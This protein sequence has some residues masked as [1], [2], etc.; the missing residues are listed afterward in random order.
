M[1][2]K[3]AITNVQVKKCSSHDPNI[4]TGIVKRFVNRAF[5]I[6]SETHIEEVLQF[7][8]DMFVE[9]GYGLSE[10][11]RVIAQVRERQTQN[12]RTAGELETSFDTNNQ[13]T[14]ITLLWIPGMSPKLRSVQKGRIQDRF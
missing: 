2:R 8:I 9:N 4:Q 5:T 11:K 14:T 6:C 7:V 12:N 10:V 1:H 3:N 13:S